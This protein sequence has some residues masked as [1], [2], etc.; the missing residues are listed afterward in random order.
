MHRQH[1]LVLILEDYEW[2]LDLVHLFAKFGIALQEQDARAWPRRD[3]DGLEATNRA[4]LLRRCV[5]L[6]VKL[7]GRV[8]FCF[9]C[10][11]VKSRESF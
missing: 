2:W 8:F 11:A 4:S 1:K 9:R 6:C 3:R 10:P 7:T 5:E